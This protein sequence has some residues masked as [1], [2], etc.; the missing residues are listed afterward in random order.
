MQDNPTE[1]VKELEKERI[2]AYNGAT[3]LNLVKPNFYRQDD[4]P[5]DKDSF[6]Q[7]TCGASNRSNQEDTNTDARSPTR[8]TNYVEFGC[9]NHDKM[10]LYPHKA[11][12]LIDHVLYLPVH[13]RVPLQDLE[14]L[15]QGILKVGQRRHPDVTQPREEL[16]N[17]FKKLAKL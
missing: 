7:D 17:E 12:F 14:Y 2:E 9:I 8:N 5:E 4:L 16:L 13:K 6:P 10:H 11:K 15:C 1:W 3:Q